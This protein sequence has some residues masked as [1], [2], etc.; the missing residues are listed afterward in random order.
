MGDV[1]NL[2]DAWEPYKA[3]RQAL[4]NTLE[5]SNV[6]E[7]AVRFHQNVAKFNPS[8]RQL[9]KEGALT[10]EAVL[11]HIPKLMNVLREC[12]VTLRWII[13]HT[14]ALYPGNLTIPFSFDDANQI[15]FLYIQ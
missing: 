10:E 1:V 11:D 13:L 4:S 14:V 8:V 2:V 15:Y 9:L 7:H 12:N 5:T 6:H 3:A